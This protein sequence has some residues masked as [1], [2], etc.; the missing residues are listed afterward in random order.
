MTHRTRVNTMNQEQTQF[1]MELNKTIILYVNLHLH[2]RINALIIYSKYTYTTNFAYIIKA[3]LVFL[4]NYIIVMP[5]FLGFIS[6]R[7]TLLSG[8]FDLAQC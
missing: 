3:K 5:F 1:M 7:F 2:M 8:K 6:D 4:S